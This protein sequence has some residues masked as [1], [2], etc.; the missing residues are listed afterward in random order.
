VSPETR[1]GGTTI[2]GA[3]DGQAP[4]LAGEGISVRFG[5]LK[6]LSGVDIAVPARSIVGL[7]GPNGAGKS[8]LINVLS[9]LQAPTSGRVFIDGADVT[10]AAT[11]QR[12]RMGLARTFQQPELFAG[13]SV[14]EHLVLAW[15]V[16]F[17]RSRMWRDL[18]DGRAWRKPRAEEDR[19]VDDLIQ[20]LGL[21]PIGNAPVAALPLGYSRLVEVGRALAGSPKVVLLD[22]PL[23]GLDGEES[24]RLAEVLMSLVDDEGVSFL[25]VDH[26]VD[27]VLARSRH[28]VVLDFGE[29]ITAGTSDEVRTSDLVRAAYLGDDVGPKGE[30]A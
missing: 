9:G 24:E 23:S 2:S 30:L 22:E 21:G 6:A 4:V 29:V 8:T 27:K 16:R 15:R 18:V 28:V 17:D 26:D 20:R 13:L 14:R 5:G 25:L 1:T 10:S 12:A 7:I 3:L 11:Q 19:R